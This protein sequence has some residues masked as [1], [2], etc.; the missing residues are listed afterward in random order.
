MKLKTVKFLILQKLVQ[1]TFFLKS[2]D[3]SELS[4]SKLQ[5]CTALAFVSTAE[6]KSGVVSFS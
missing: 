2:L 3:T 6:V 4:K 5:N 1:P